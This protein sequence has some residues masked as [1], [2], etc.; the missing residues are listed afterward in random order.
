M[1][2]ARFQSYT[3]D[4]DFKAQET[5]QR[6]EATMS[7]TLG[8]SDWAQAEIT[9]VKLRFNQFC[10]IVLRPL[11]FTPLTAASLAVCAYTP[12]NAVN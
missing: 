11:L 12:C 3:A 6:I 9:A 4:T 7:A 2:S 8:V 1:C 5:R 10:H